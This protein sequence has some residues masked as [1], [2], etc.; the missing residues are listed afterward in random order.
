MRTFPYTITNATTGAQQKS[1]CKHIRLKLLVNTT[2]LLLSFET[3]YCKDPFYPAHKPA[4]SAYT[5]LSERA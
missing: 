1:G 4:M 2:S 3:S 5:V